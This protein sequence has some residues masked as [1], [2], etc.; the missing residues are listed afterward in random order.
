MTFLWIYQHIQWGGKKMSNFSFE[1]ERTFIEAEM[2][3]LTMGSNVSSPR[4]DQNFTVW[5]EWILNCNFQA[6]NDPSLAPWNRTKVHQKATEWS[7]FSS[8]LTAKRWVSCWAS[9]A[10][11]ILPAPLL[12]CGG[13]GSS[14]LSGILC[15]ATGDTIKFPRVIILAPC[16][17]HVTKTLGFIHTLSPWVW[18]SLKKN[19]A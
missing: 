7:C 10:H 6:Q 1:I 15:V 5:K 9:T 17:G 4:S 16:Y 14:Q 12:Q 11:T 8:E 2:L 3:G 13:V 19:G 18:I